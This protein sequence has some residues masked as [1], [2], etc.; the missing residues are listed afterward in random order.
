MKFKLFN[1][2]ESSDC[3]FACVKMISEYF[4]YSVSIEELKSLVDFSR[5]GVS[6]KNICELLTTLRIDSAVV[7]ATLDNLNDSPLPI[8]LYWEQKH[9]VVLYKIDKKGKYYIADPAMGK[10]KF[11]ANEFRNHWI[12]KNNSLGLAILAEPSN[13]FKKKNIPLSESFLLAF[14]KFIS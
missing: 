2:L 3:G 6:I 11:T 8:I 14:F 10:M 7:R 5:Q 1:Q 12:Q 9:F 4:G 13:T